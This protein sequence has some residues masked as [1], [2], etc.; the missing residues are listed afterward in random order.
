MATCFNTQGTLKTKDDRQLGILE[1]GRGKLVHT[2]LFFCC[3]RVQIFYGGSTST[4]QSPHVNHF[5]LELHFG[6]FLSR[7]G[8]PSISSPILE[9]LSDSAAQ[10]SRGGG[11]HELLIIDLKRS[12]DLRWLLMFGAIFISDDLVTSI[13]PESNRKQ[14]T[15][16]C[17]VKV[18]FYLCFMFFSIFSFSTQFTIF[19]GLN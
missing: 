5:A 16:I 11:R 17:F 8:R 3:E 7:P 9:Q 19:T 12:I 13:C 14:K 10:S 15:H 2:P 6:L 1:T 18:E 4:F